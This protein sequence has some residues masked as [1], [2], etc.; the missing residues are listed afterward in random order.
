MDWLG[1]PIYDCLTATA[2]GS[3]AAQLGKKQVLSETFAL[4]GHGVELNDLKRIYE[5]QMVRGINL[6]CPHLEGYSLRGI[7][8]RDYPP[9]MYC[10]QPWWDDADTFFDSL[11]RIGMLLTEGKISADT[12]VIINQTTA[13]KLYCGLKVPGSEDARKKIS[14]SRFGEAEYLLDTVP[15]G[16]RPAEWYY[17]KACVF[18]DKGAFMDALRHA[19]VAC[20]MA[21]SNGEYKLLRDNLQERGNAYARQTTSQPGNAGCD[22]CDICSLLICLDCM[23]R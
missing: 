1:R 9:A 14:E 8:K 22:M 2:L 15:E 19:N 13:W 3:A 16:A 6:L 4:A 12:L 23:C 5:W 11:S 7:R 20:T 18:T 10:Q 21:P 17:L